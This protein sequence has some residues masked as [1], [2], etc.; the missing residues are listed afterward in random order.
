MLLV[1]ASVFDSCLTL[2]LTVVEYSM[3]HAVSACSGSMC[4]E[5]CADCQSNHAERDF[6]NQCRQCLVTSVSIGEIKYEILLGEPDE[7]R[8][9]PVH[10]FVL[11]SCQFSA[12]VHESP[13][14]VWRYEA[15]SMN[16]LPA[17][18]CSCCCLGQDDIYEP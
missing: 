3:Q 12:L 11:F 4:Q 17:R 7:K 18:R 13:C 6:S 5:Y 14:L 10:F 15:L 9:W 16:L 2:S 8:A 1:V